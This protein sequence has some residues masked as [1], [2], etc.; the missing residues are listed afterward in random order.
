MKDRCNSVDV[1]LSGEPR[2][3]LCRVNFSFVCSSPFCISQVLG[4]LFF[5]PNIW[6]VC[7]VCGGLHYS[8]VFGCVS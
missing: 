4:I 3:F 5:I 1:A 2:K 6:R 7:S 8:F